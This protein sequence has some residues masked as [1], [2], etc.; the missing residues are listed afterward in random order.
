MDS[1]HDMDGS[2]DG[3]PEDEE[4]LQLLEEEDTER[5]LVTPVQDEP[6]ALVARLEAAVGEGEVPAGARSTK[7]ENM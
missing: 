6:E 3:A 4:G 7:R 2:I 5:L 1:F